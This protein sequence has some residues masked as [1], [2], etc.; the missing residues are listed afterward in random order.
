MNKL[1]NGNVKEKINAATYMA[2]NKVIEAIP[3]LIENI[4]NKDRY[5]W[6][7]EPKGGKID[8][9]CVVTYALDQITNVNIGDTCYIFERP[10]EEY[11]TIKQNWKGW[12]ENKY[13]KYEN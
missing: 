11:E 6:E 12:Y 3:L 8:V 4:D 5:F 7:K 9:S 1:R 2:D 10:Q 13:M